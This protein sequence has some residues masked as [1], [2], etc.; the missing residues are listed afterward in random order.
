MHIHASHNVSVASQATTP[1]GPVPTFRFLL[2]VTSR[3][4]AAG[5][6]LT[7]TEAHDADLCALVPQ[8]V[9]VFAVFPLTHALGSAISMPSMKTLE[10]LDAIA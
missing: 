8:I 7:A 9:L 2:P 5:S 10:K 1:T 4:V 3:T 6:P